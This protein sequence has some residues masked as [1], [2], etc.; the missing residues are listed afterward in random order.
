MTVVLTVKAEDWRSALEQA[1]DDGAALLEG[2]TAIDRI[3]HLEVVAV[4]RDPREGPRLIATRIPSDGPSLPSIV[5]VLPGAEW[6]ERETAEMFGM[7]FTDHPDPRSLIL[8]SVPATLVAPL[9]KSSPLAER[10]VRPWPGAAP[11]EAAGRR[12]R[13]PAAPGVRDEWR[14][15][16]ASS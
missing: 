7:Q 4:L 6:W 12:R 9:R 14:E 5:D 11:P 1:R 15:S 13:A 2:L 3:D 8:A 10:V 16:G